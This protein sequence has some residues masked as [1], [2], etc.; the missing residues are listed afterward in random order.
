MTKIS[1]LLLDSSA[2]IFDD[3][4]DVPLLTLVKNGLTGPDD[5]NRVVIFRIFKL[6][7]DST[8][9]TCGLFRECAKVCDKEEDSKYFN[10]VATLFENGLDQFGKEIHEY[11]DTDK[12]KEWI[13]VQS[14]PVCY[15][16]SFI[17][18]Y[19]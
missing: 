12:D 13:A 4:K 8:E 1:K 2:N 7:S 11:F 6:F 17:V 18:F 5:H 9:E 19:V 16:L 10:E 3:F 14:E 15:S